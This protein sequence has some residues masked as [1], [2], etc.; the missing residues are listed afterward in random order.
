MTNA[1]LVEK[2]K[3]Y[4]MNT[5]GR[6]PIALVRGKGCYV[7]DADDKEY[8][9]FVAG[10]AVNALGHCHPVVIEAI[11]KQVENLIHCS[12][13]YWIEPQIDLAQLLIENSCMD[14]AFFCNSGAEANEG[15][16]KLS[17]K[18]AKEQA[19]PQKF[20]II[21]MQNSFHGRT[22][23]TLTATGQKKLQKN[24]D[25]LPQGFCYADFND[26]ESVKSKI[27]ES[28][29]AIL[30]E[31]VQG[32]GGVVVADPQ[33][34]AG[35]R[36][37][38]DRH[39]LLLIFDEVQVG[40]C[41]TGKLFAY[42]HSGVQPDVITLAKALAGGAP[43]GA[44]LA[45]GKAAETFAPGDHASTFGGNPLVTSAGVATLSYMLEQDLAGHVAKMS[46]YMQEKMRALMKKHAFIKEVRGQGLLLGLLLEKEGA[47]IVASCLTKGLLINCTAGTVLRFVPPL[48]V[49]EKEIDKAIA[50]LDESLAEE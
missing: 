34:L 16:I 20:E 32:E 48:V 45:R 40:M 28:T 5:Y 33:F 19:N 37:L 4:I 39:D 11:Q 27:T 35:L 8:L 30:V 25:P 47:P 41:R 49:T 15:A 50:I 43:I 14:K 42:E 44:L 22:L 36:Q 23:A 3:K 7:Y 24:F 46:A 29:C 13:L 9:D 38:C 17:R 26:L 12:N 1:Q 2:G 18:Y 31:P 10:I 6:L 21:S